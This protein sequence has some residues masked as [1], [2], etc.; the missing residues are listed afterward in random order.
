[1][2]YTPRQPLT[3]GGRLESLN[4][5]NKLDRLPPDPFQKRIR[6]NPASRSSVDSA[7]NSVVAKSTSFIGRQSITARPPGMPPGGGRL[8]EMNAELKKAPLPAP[9]K[10]DIIDALP[11]DLSEANR[12]RL[13]KFGKSMVVYDFVQEHWVRPRIHMA[14]PRRHRELLNALV[15]PVKNADVLDIACGTGGAI[16]SF[17]SSN[18]YT[19]LDLSYAMLKQAVK[20]AGKKSFGMS[21]FVQGNA[22]NLLFDNESFDFVLMDTALHMI[23]DYQQAISETARVLASGGTWVCSTPVVGISDAFDANWKKIAGKRALHSL[24]EAI[25]EDACLRNGL[26]YDHYATNGGVLYFQARKK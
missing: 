24:T 18:R 13:K 3:K 2:R 20:K 15:A 7:G 17:D 22:E 14:V 9:D 5:D 1:L 11:D 6:F 10:N 26:H 19:G 16:A 12:K 4:G 21:R 8:K 23:P 25:L